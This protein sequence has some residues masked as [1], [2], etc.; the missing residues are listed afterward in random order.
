MQKL[1]LDLMVNKQQQTQVNYPG[2]IEHLTLRG[3]SYGS[4][5]FW[6]PLSGFANKCGSTD[7]DSMEIMSIKTC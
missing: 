1:Q 6:L 7:P 3:S 4:A 5:S 2:V